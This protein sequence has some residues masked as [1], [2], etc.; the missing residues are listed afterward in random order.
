MKLNYS[1]SDYITLI[2]EKNAS[3]FVSL[4]DQYAAILY[5]I[6]LK[7]TEDKTQ[8]EELLIQAFVNIRKNILNYDLKKKQ[9]IGYMLSEARTLALNAISSGQ[10]KT[11]YK[12]LLTNSVL[13]E[14]SAASDIPLQFDQSELKEVNTKLKQEHFQLISLAYF[15]G[16]S[17]KEMA[18][19]LDIPEDDVNKRLKIAI[20]Q[21]HDLIKG[22]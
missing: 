14:V 2:T 18:S 5:G 20:Q 16:C 21:L 15:K 19:I 22:K 3:A 10:S 17:R 1:D 13:K 4:Y 6:L 12:N 9:L 7:M 8:A 11:D